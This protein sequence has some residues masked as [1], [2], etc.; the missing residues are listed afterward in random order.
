[1][2]R[3]ADLNI[4]IRETE[5]GFEAQ[6]CYIEDIRKLEKQYK[7]APT[8][9]RDVLRN[10]IDRMAMQ[11]KN[12]DELLQRLQNVGYTIKRGKYLAIKP[13]DSTH[14]IRIKSLGEWFSEQAIRNRL[15]Q[16]MQFE[17]NIDN[18]INTAKDPDAPET[19]VYKTI[20][21]YTTIFIQHGALPIRK[22]KKKKPFTWENC[23]EL[24]KLAGLNK[25]INEGLTLE[26]L[27]KD[28]KVFEERVAD[29]DRI[30]SEINS[31]EKSYYDNQTVADIKAALQ[32][33]RAKLKD[34]SDTL[35]LME[36]V[37]SGT[38]VQS[39]IDEEMQRRQSGSLG[40]GLKLADGTNSEKINKI[41]MKFLTSE[42]PKLAEPEW[43]SNPPTQPPRR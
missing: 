18:K 14:F 25:K 20:K 4:P 6:Q 16:K 43:L 23:E 9:Q 24:D 15:I 32:E 40:N 10:H 19:F 33:D 13:Q 1:M 35:T 30:V 38:Y 3:L 34:V 31:G 27:R 21:H 11:S 8:S 42:N 5:N 26:G 36:K 28:F 39:I 17:K 12:F 7:P 37:L 41:S 22:V 2:S 29:L